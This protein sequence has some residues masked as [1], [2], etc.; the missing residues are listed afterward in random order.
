MQAALKEGNVLLLRCE[1]ES[2]R[3]NI[4]ILVVFC[5]FTTVGIVVTHKTPS[6][7]IERRFCK[8]KKNPP[9]WKNDTIRHS[10]KQHISPSDSPPTSIC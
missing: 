8:E 6:F 7:Y 5:S 1:L 2:S 10:N 3:V 9:P 4:S